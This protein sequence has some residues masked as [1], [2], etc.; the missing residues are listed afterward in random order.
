[1]ESVLDGIVVQNEK[2]S[3][4]Y[5]FGEN[6]L[7]VFPSVTIDSIFST[8]LNFLFQTRYSTGIIAPDIFHRTHKLPINSKNNK[9]VIRIKFNNTHST[10]LVILE[11]FFWYCWICRFLLFFMKSKID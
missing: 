10:M 9:Y 6:P 7:F 4:I 3:K 11:T 1:M 5:D 8:I 2:I